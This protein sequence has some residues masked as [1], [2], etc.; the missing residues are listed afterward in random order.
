MPALNYK[1]E[2]VHK[3]KPGLGQTIRPAGKPVRMK[4]FRPGVKLYHFTGMRTKNCRKLGESTVSE[5]VP[6][7]I[8]RIFE[9]GY[10]FWIKNQ[11]ITTWEILRLAKEDGFEY[12]A[13]DPTDSP[14]NNMINFF[15]NAYKLKINEPKEFVII[16]WQNFVPAGEG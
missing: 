2:V 7:T 11:L 16:K 8:K 13:A 10:R 15:Q 14:I 3:L 9:H 12:D 5:V 1:K 6:I 4:Q